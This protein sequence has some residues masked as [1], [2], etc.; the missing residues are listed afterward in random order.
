[1]EILV[2][3]QLEHVIFQSNKQESKQKLSEVN[4]LVINC[5]Q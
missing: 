5:Y 3:S 2:R 4:D 1:M